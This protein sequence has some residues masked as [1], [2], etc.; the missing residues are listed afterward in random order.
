MHHV[1]ASQHEG[2]GGFVLGDA[3]LTP[4]VSTDL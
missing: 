4:R 2:G 1:A 3:D